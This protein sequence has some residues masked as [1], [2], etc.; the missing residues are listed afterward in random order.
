M[1]CRAT[2]NDVREKSHISSK[3]YSTSE[4]SCEVQMQ[5]PRLILKYVLAQWLNN[6]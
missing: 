5:L 2:S 1:T 4:G 6:L 3:I